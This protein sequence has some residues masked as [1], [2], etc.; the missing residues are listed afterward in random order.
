VRWHTAG[1]LLLLLA[2]LLPPPPPPPLMMMMMRCD[3]LPMLD[4]LTA[5]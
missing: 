5:R 2:L 4:G 1:R 3:A